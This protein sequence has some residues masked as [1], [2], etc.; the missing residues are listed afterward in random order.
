MFVS[1]SKA[2]QNAVILLDK[3]TYLLDREI[4]KMLVRAC[5]GTRILRSTLA[6]D[7][8]FYGQLSSISENDN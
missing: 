1:L 4:I 6:H 3:I 7:F 5:V 8:V 2:S